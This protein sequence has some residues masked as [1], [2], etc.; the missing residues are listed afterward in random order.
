MLLTS[1]VKDEFLIL[2]SPFI[3]FL[4]KQKQNKI[5][6]SIQ[7]KNCSRVHKFNKFDLLINTQKNQTG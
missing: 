5:C 6:M 7:K 2:K 1:K 3:F 4:L